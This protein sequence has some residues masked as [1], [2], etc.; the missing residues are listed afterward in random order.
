LRWRSDTV[1]R[2]RISAASFYR[3][4]CVPSTAT[5]WPPSLLLA[6]P[7]LFLDDLPFFL[8]FPPSLL[9]G[10]SAS[11]EIFQVAIGAQG[12]PPAAPGG[13]PGFFSILGGTD[14]Q[15]FDGLA[16]RD[17]EVRVIPEPASAALLLPGLAGVA[18]G[19]RRK[20][21]CGALPA[22]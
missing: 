22:G 12:A 21:G 11:G 18:V 14:D 9:P 1:R 7:G 2:P 5:R 17:F 10:A 13:Y 19:R 16:T 20:A 3:A 6:G 4:G 8:N 15:A